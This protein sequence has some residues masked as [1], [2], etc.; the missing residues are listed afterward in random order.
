MIK[1]TLKNVSISFGKKFRHNQNYSMVF[2]KL[3][4]GVN[5]NTTKDELFKII[6]NYY[7]DRVLLNNS[8]KL[9]IERNS[10]KDDLE[11]KK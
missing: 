5:E 8:S 10:Y 11:L 3:I 1:I 6:K 7:S 2:W 9:T 4:D